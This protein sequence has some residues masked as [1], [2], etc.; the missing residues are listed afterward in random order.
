MKTIFYDFYNIYKNVSWIFM[1][2]I[3]WNSNHESYN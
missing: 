1:Q 3:N 2:L